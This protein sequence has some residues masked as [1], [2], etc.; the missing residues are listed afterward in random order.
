MA[1]LL[2]AKIDKFA[3]TH[4]SVLGWLLYFKI[5]KSANRGNNLLKIWES[6][7][8]A[9]AEKYSNA[10]TMLFASALM[11]YLASDLY[12]QHMCYNFYS[13]IYTPGIEQCHCCQNCQLCNK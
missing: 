6:M 8:I 13:T 2:R 10:I 3:L 4:K 5:E 7:K 12:L 9:M 1:K 11:L